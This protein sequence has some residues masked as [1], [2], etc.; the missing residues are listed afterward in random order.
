[1]VYGN[2][3]TETD[4]KS[5]YEGKEDPGHSQQIKVNSFT[6]SLLDKRREVLYPISIAMEAVN[7]YGLRVG[8]SAGTR[9]EG[10]TCTYQ[11]LSACFRNL[12]NAINSTYYHVITKHSLC[13]TCGSQWSVK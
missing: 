7:S 2:K 1:M 11:F 8:E 6:V 9:A 13:V 4:L 10:S 5:K 3:E 12:S